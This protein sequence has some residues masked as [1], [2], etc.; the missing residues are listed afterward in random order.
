MLMRL[1]CWIISSG[2]CV[3]CIKVFNK[4]LLSNLETLA[5]TNGTRKGVNTKPRLLGPSALK[6]KNK[7]ESTPFDKMYPKWLVYPKT[8]INSLFTRYILN[9]EVGEVSE[10]LKLFRSSRLV[11]K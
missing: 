1:H 10:S 2:Q 7:S 5:L 4:N 3:S 6:P 8:K 11:A 9:G